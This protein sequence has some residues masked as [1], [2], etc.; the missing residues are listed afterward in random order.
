MF[1]HLPK[2]A[3]TDRD[4]N[5]FAARSQIPYFRGVFMRDELVNCRPL[6]N[7]S[8]VVNLDDSAGPGTH[9]CAYKKRGQCVIWF[10]SFGDLRPP[11]EII[12]YFRGCEIYYNHSRYQRFNTYI[13]GHLCLQFLQKVT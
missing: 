12:Q 11:H 7:E 4:I 5:S 2:R 6:R 3:L 13:C 9:W 10:D 8:A 1:V